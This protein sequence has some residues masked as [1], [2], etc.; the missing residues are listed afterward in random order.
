MSGAAVDTSRWTV[1]ANA[2][3][4][5]SSSTYDCYTKQSTIVFSNRVATLTAWRGHTLQVSTFFNQLPNGVYTLQNGVPILEAVGFRF[6]QVSKKT[7]TIVEL[8]IS[9]L[10]DGKNPVGCLPDSTCIGW[11]TGRGGLFGLVVYDLDLQNRVRPLFRVAFNEGLNA[12]G[13]QWPTCTGNAPSASCSMYGY[14]L[15]TGA[16]SYQMPNTTLPWRVLVIYDP[17]DNS[18]SGKITGEG[19]TDYTIPKVLSLTSASLDTALGT[20]WYVFF[21]YVVNP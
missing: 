9:S 12:F 20:Y 13:V 6:G 2:L 1:R 3:C 5:L 21:N 18:F 15:G 14:W 17:I 8:T 19:L 10:N 4:Y 11:N 7:K 16:S